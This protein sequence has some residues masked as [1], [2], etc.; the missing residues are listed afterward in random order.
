MTKKETEETTKAG[1]TYGEIWRAYPQLRRLGEVKIPVRA[2][3]KI[4]EY[5]SALE[6]PYNNIEKQRLKLLNEYVEEDKKTKEKKSLIPGEEKYFAFMD[7]WDEI[8]AVEWGGLIKIERVKLSERISGTCDACHHNMDV[9][10]LIEPSI[11]A[12]LVEKFVEV[13]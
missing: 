3:A 4:G 6:R 5:V 8:L 9:E 1:L 12:P 2:S 13:I 11:L 7:K 10:F